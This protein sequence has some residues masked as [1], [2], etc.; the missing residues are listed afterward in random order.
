VRQGPLDRKIRG[1]K[2]HS[3]IPSVPK[4]QELIPDPP[5]RANLIVVGRGPPDPPVQWGCKGQSQGAG[6]RFF[7]VGSLLGIRRQPGGSGGPR[8][9]GAVAPSRGLPPG[10]SASAQ[11]KRGQELIID[12]ISSPP[13]VR[14]PSIGKFEGLN[15]PSS[16]PSVPKN[17]ELLPDPPKRCGC[18]RAFMVGRGPP[19]PPGWVSQTRRRGAS[20]GHAL[21]ALP[22]P[23]RKL[24]RIFD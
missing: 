1:A 4:N 6:W 23:L 7:C 5:K 14:I 19:D 3:S 17:Q 20:G 11:S 24:S 22:R 10:G 9:T 13:R 16:I 12:I 15:L 2:S 18:L 8:P 21:P